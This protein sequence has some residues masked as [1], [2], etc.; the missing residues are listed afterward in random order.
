VPV[1]VV[2]VRGDRELSVLS[3]DGCGVVAV[4]AMASGLRLGLT[5]S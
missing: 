5:E 3:P 4:D 1:V 2:V